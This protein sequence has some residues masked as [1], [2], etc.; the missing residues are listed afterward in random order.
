[1]KDAA[2]GSVIWEEGK[3]FSDPSGMH[4]VRLPTNVLDRK[5]VV[6]EM[7][8]ATVEDLKNLRLVHYAKF[9]GKL[10]ERTTFEMGAVKGG[11]INTWI[12]T[13]DAAP[14]SSMM[15]AKVLSGKLTIETEF[16]D[17]DEKFATSTI[18]LFFV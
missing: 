15:P 11:T 17:E 13:I 3:D 7:N 6:R 12:S 5:A 4:E 10:L 8:F 9:K 18:K 2:D 16:Y 1:M 14:E